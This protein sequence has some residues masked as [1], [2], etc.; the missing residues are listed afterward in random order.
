MASEPET[1][2]SHRSGERASCTPNQVPA[3]EQERI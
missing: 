2:R 3:R 1:T